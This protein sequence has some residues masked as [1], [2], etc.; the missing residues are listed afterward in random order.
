MFFSSQS[1]AKEKKEND[2]QLK[3]EKKIAKMKK[4]FSISIVELNFRCKIS[5]TRNVVFFNNN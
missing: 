4:I 3:G 2:K 1:K 5:F